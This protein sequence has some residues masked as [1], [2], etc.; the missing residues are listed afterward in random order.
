MS[1]AEQARRDAWIRR[2]VESLGSLSGEQTTRLRELLP[3]V[4]GAR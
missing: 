3:P 1:P 2:T 4:R